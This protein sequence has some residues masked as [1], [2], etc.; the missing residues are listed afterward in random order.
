MRKSYTSRTSFEFF[1]VEMDGRL[2]NLSFIASGEYVDMGIGALDVAGRPVV[3]SYFGIEEFEVEDFT[4]SEHTPEETTM[5]LDE[6]HDKGLIRKLIDW[7]YDNKSDEIIAKLKDD[8]GSEDE[9]GM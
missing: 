4:A 3:D 2:F 6:F 8:R 9:D 1:D 7:V 5:D